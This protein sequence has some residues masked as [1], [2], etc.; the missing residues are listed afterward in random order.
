MH[1]ET[2]DRIYMSKDQNEDCIY[3]TEHK[4]KRFPSAVN[5]KESLDHIRICIFRGSM[6]SHGRQSVHMDRQTGVSLQSG[7]HT[8][9]HTQVWNTIT[10][11]NMHAVFLPEN[12]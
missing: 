10:Y 4:E 2:V 1:E 6:L 5:R 7:G 8:T 3:N 11:D 12:G 9:I